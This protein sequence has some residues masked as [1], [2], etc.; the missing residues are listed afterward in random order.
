MMDKL[1][2]ALEILSDVGSQ[3]EALGVSIKQQISQ[4]EQADT[5]REES[6]LIL[7]WSP[8]KGSKLGDFETA[9][10]D[11]NDPEKYQHALSILKANHAT[12]DERLH[13]PQFQHT[14]WTY[15][16]TIYRQLRKNKQ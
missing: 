1:E 5:V 8:K 2:K 7:S 10:K 11:S 14:Y 9:T 3:L 16:D 12:I 4:I 15:Q 13:E 6:F